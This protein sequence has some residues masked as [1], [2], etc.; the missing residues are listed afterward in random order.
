MAMTVSCNFCSWSLTS[1]DV[2]DAAQKSNE[3]AA[4]HD[5]GWAFSAGSRKAHYFRG[6][7]RS[8]CGRYG[9]IGMPPEAFERE[10]KPSTDDCAGCRRRLDKE[11]VR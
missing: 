5:K 6:D 7:R 4:T 3:H 11:G 1:E 8:L 2:V 10:S 9:C